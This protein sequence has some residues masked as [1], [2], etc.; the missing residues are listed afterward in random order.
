M[1]IAKKNDYESKL[2]KYIS[3]IWQNWTAANELLNKCNN[4]KDFPSYFIINGDKIDNKED[5]GNNFNYFFQNIGPTISANIP[6]H[7]DNIIKTFLKEKITFFFQFSLLEQGTVS[8]IINKINSKHNCGHENLPAILMIN[9]LPSHIIT[10]HFNL[11]SIAFLQ[12]F[13]PDSLKTA[14]IIPLLKK[15]KTLINLINIEQHHSCQHSPKYLDQ[16]SLD[17]YMIIS[18]KIIFCTKA[19]MDLALRIQQI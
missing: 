17:N 8:K 12:K 19:Y 2:N 3:N 14:K 10:N 9:K 7:E 1:N 16:L 11:K 13:C 6:Q 18:T 5:I 4:E 15:N